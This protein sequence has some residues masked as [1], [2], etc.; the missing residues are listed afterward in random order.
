M[1]S[2]C[3]DRTRCCVLCRTG[4]KGVLRL[5]EGIVCGRLILVVMNGDFDAA[6]RQLQSDPSANATRAF[7]YQ[8]MLFAQR[9]IDL[10]RG[11]NLS[12]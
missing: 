12:T 2:C 8:R 7:G 5:F 1:N 10:L 9:R 3:D 11:A 6:L 4:T